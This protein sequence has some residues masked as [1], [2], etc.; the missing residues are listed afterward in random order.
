MSIGLIRLRHQRGLP[1]LCTS[2]ISFS[3][4]SK[5][6]PVLR[7]T[8]RHFCFSLWM[9]V[10]DSDV[11]IVTPLL[12]VSGPCVRHKTLVSYQALLPIMRIRVQIQSSLQLWPFMKVITGYKWDYTCYKWGFLSTYNWYFGP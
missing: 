4:V 9:R 5:A 7:A 12:T 10:S 11:K 3:W 8:G 2:T 1:V 6:K